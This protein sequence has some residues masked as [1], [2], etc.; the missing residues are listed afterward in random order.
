M[1]DI[2]FVDLL[3]VAFAFL[4][5][6]VLYSRGKPKKLPFPPGPSRL[7]VIGNLLDMPDGAEWITYKRWG[8]LYGAQIFLY[9]SA[10]LLMCCFGL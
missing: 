9:L 10:T 8:N 3:V 6:S 2:G 4:A 5:F 1:P 7:P